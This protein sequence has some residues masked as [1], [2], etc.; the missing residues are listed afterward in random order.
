V[1]PSRPTRN[2]TPSCYPL[3]AKEAPNRA[4]HRGRFGTGGK[5]KRI[6]AAFGRAHQRDLSSIQC[7]SVLSS[8]EHRIV[9]FGNP[10]YRAIVVREEV[11]A[12]MTCIAPRN[13]IL[14]PTSAYID[15]VDT[16]FY[17]GRTQRHSFR[18]TAL[19]TQTRF[20]RSCQINATARQ[21]RAQ[22]T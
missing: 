1:R 12:W 18:S 3:M 19:K 11:I 16:I 21:V 6:H 5:G 14:K 7:C 10:G 20:G 13:P 22:L 17:S 8:I 4:S 15:P 9:F 2:N